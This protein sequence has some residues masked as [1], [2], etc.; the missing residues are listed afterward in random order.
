MHAGDKDTLVPVEAMAFLASQLPN[1][2]THIERGQG[3][4]IASV[5]WG[6]I[7]LALTHRQI[8]LK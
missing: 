3:H 4:E 8:E 6:H 1:T 7:V 2:E 5:R